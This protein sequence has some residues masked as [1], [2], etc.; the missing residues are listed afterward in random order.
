[1]WIVKIRKALLDALIPGNPLGTPAQR[2]DI[3]RAPLQQRCDDKLAQPSAGTRNCNFGHFDFSEFWMQNIA[4]PLGQPAISA[5]SEK[6][7][8]HTTSFRRHTEIVN[9]PVVPAHAP[10]Y[11]DI[12]MKL[13][14]RSGSIAFLRA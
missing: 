7:P 5:W 3:A 1:L 14:D 4:L 6:N 8:C 2:H 13:T 11:R 12:T 10:A 9:R